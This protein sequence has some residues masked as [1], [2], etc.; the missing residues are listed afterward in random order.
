[1]AYPEIL[2]DIMTNDILT[3]FC[4]LCCVLLTCFFLAI[5]WRF[6]K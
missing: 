1:M 5:I 6:R 2:I 3:M 4:N